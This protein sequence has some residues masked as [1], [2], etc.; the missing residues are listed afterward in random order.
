MPCGS[1]V[2]SITSCALT[3]LFHVEGDRC[4]EEAS[5]GSLSFLRTFNNFL[6]NSEQTS[7][8]KHGRR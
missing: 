5:M 1:F 6:K 4:V 7:K 8:G 3:T 2:A